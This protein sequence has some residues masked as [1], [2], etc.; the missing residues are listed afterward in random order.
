MRLTDYFHLIGAPEVNA[1]ANEDEISVTETRLGGRFP[2]GLR[3]WFR[4]ANGFE[5]E[6][7]TNMWRFKSLSRLHTISDVFGKAETLVAREG[8]PER[9]MMGG[10]Y[11]IVCDALIYLPFYAV[12]IRPDSPHYAEVLSGHD[13]RGPGRDEAIDIWFA[14]PN[15]EAF[16]DFLFKYPDECFYYGD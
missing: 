8:Y 6:A 4:E 5:G 13:G 15:F 11:V 2:E 7:S 9:R 16:E 14:T 12:N 3:R 10:E 1:G